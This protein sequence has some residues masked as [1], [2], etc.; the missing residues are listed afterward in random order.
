MIEELLE[1]A[2]AA[3][4]RVELN[5]AKG[6]YPQGYRVNLTLCP[7]GHIS[8]SLTACVNIG[9][10]EYHG[11]VPHELTFYSLKSEGGWEN[12][13]DIS[14]L[15]EDGDEWENE[16]T[17]DVDTIFTELEKELNEWID[18]GNYLVISGI[19]NRTQC[20]SL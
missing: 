10:A 4:D 20:S 14:P 17:Y 9:A 16:P 7:D 1:K 15:S 5:N 6:I 8:E 12:V 13:T 18:A 3:I 11:I 19:G 2:M